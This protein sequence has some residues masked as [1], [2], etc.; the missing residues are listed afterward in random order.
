[1]MTDTL[2]TEIRAHGVRVLQACH[3]LVRRLKRQNTPAVHGNKLWASS[4]LLI[5][6]I[7]HQGLKKDTR[8]MEVGCGW[9]LA[10][11]Y[12]AKKHGAL[13]TSVDIDPEVF[14]YL[15]LHADINRVKV[16]P[17]KRS[18]NGLTR[19]HLKDVDIMI[20]ADICF[21]DSMV[22]PLKGLVRRALRERV[23]QVLIADPGRTSFEDVGDYFIK[24]WGGRIFDWTAQRPRRIQGRILEIHPD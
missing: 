21:W 6:Y 7:K 11:I 8:V 22:A 13:V 10:G 2:N 16:T 14:P 1:M 12:C 24:K 20:G 4:W 19:E 5:D 3:S 17:M 23:G 9:G 18:F 15:Q